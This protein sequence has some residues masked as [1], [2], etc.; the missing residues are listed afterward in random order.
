MQCTLL[1]CPN[2]CNS[3]PEEAHE[4]S[5]LSPFAGRRLLSFHIHW[6]LLG[7]APSDPL[8]QFLR[9]CLWLTLVLRH[10]LP[11]L[12]CHY[13]ECKPLT[14]LG[15]WMSIA[16]YVIVALTHC[17][18]LCCVHLWL[19][20]LYSLSPLHGQRLWLVLPCSPVSLWSRDNT[21]LL[22]IVFAIETAM[23]AVGKET[24]LKE[25]PAS[26]SS[27]EISWI[28]L[29]F[30]CVGGFTAWGNG[31]MELCIQ[32]I[33][34]VHL[35]QQSPFHFSFP[36]LSYD[37]HEIMHDS[38]TLSNSVSLTSTWL[39]SELVLGS[40]HYCLNHLEVKKYHWYT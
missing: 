29:L 38:A 33:L 30:L 10:T 20:L 31:L 16:R 9:L 27:L 23:L 4:R 19:Q 21:V 15:V 36:F 6:T 3:F 17:T 13:T 5:L 18:I 37:R 22:F 12:L 40:L 39:S 7:S 32:F 11:H 34:L 2:H 24:E 1:L 25:I 14:R 26:S 8:C 28:L 35:L